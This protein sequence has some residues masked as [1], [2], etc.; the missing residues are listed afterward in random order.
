MTTK[1][2]Y[3]AALK[4]VESYETEIN[5]QISVKTTCICCKTKEIKQLY[6]DRS[7]SVLELQ[8]ESWSDGVVDLI[9]F[10][11]GSKF[12]LE[13]FYIA[14]CDDCIEDLFKKGL[15]TRYRDI[16]KNLRE[17]KSN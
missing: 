17:L 4:T 5:R 1:E 6:D 16:T 7:F 12:D 15:V 8:K 13:R 10:G 14:I 3:E 11:F 9:S 2:E